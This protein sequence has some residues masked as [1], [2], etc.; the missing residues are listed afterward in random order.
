MLERRRVQL[1][2][3]LV[4]MRSRFKAVRDG[5]ARSLVEHDCE[6]AE[7]DLTW[8]D[9]LIASE[10]AGRA[11][12]LLLPPNPSTAASTVPTVPTI[13]TAPKV[14]TAPTVSSGSPAVSISA[15]EARSGPGSTG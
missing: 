9:R 2:E 11:P 1:V 5:Y 6:S 14:P 4:K 10:R 7:R 8:I 12:G 3:R 13:P 15:V